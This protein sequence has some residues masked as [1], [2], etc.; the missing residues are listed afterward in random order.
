MIPWLKAAVD[1]IIFMIVMS[2]L[3]ILMIIL[4]D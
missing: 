4:G 2:L 3:I 1:T